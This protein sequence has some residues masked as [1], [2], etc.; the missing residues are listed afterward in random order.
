VG[1]WGEKHALVSLDEWRSQVARY[2]VTEKAIIAIRPSTGLGCPNALG[3]HGKV[4]GSHLYDLGSYVRIR[5]EI[6]RAVGCKTC[7]WSGSRAIAK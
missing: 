7:G 4:C 5:G 1:D 3:H 6:G 2:M